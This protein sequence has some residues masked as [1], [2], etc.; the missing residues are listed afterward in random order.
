MLEDINE[1]KEGGQ[2]EAMWATR[3]K[4]IVKWTARCCYSTDVRCMSG[5][6]FV[7][8]REA[9]ITFAQIYTFTHGTTV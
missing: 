1:C 7:S 2:S 3:K 5:G 9:L 8:F 4:K 6:T